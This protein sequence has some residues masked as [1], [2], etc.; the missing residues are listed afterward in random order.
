VVEQSTVNR[1][2][3][4]SNPTGGAKENTSIYRGIFCYL[5]WMFELKDKNTHKNKPFCGTSL[6]LFENILHIVYNIY[7]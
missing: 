2:V 5:G 3:V 4:G 1:W 6:L 7:I